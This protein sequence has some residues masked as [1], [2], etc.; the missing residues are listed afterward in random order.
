MCWGVLVATNT[1]MGSAGFQGHFHWEM[2]TDSQS[3]SV[4]ESREVSE[5]V[6]TH[7]HCHR[8]QRLTPQNSQSAPKCSSRR[9]HQCRG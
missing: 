5:L 1:G 7:H 8:P 4:R 2:V 3:L 6:W 9:L